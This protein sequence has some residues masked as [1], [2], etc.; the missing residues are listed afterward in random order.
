MA[1]VPNTTYGINS[2]VKSIPFETD[3]VILCNT[4]NYGAV[5]NACHSAITR[6]GGRMETLQMSIPITSSS[7]VLDKYREILTRVSNIRL[8]V[9]DFISSGTATLWPL[10]ELMTLCKQ[11]NALVLVDGAHSPGQVPI[12]LEE[13]GNTGM[14]FFTGN[15]HKWLFCP[16]GCAIQW[17]NPR[18]HNTIR[19]VITSHAYRS[20]IQE[21]FFTQGTTD[22]T[23]FLVVSDA[24]QYYNSKGGYEK[25]A[26]HN[27]ALLD[28]AVK[29]L[30]SKWNTC[31]FP[32]PDDMVAPFMRL[33]RVPD[34]T[35]ATGSCEL[36]INK[37]YE[38]YAITAL[39]MTIG[40]EP[41]VRLSAHI[42]NDINDYKRLGDAI[43]EIE[44]EE[45][46]IC[47]IIK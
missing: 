6:A 46:G 47:E 13:L 4:W 8:V 19:P 15:L 43:L 1:F 33:V 11:H 37:L 36:L 3:D 30:V 7:C 12:N 44:K 41:W 31:A 20:A 21:Q 5:L 42:Y 24:L 29:L 38:E 27:T 32:Q 40:G 2:V 22:Q 25:I 18:H 23:S 26:G 14:D 9:L 28:Q 35:C 16:R 10:T 17:I 34:M 39:I 45:K